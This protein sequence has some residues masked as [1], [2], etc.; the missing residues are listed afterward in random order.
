MATKLSL[1]SR[2]HSAARGYHWRQERE[3]TEATAQ[4]WLDIFEK[5]EPGVQFVV[6]A[7]RPFGTKVA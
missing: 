5:D 7:H 3:V 1:W 4:D 2:R 6:S